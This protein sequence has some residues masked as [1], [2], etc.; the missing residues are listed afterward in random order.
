MRSWFHKKPE[1]SM[2]SPLRT[3]FPSAPPSAIV[4]VHTMVASQCLGTRRT[5]AGC[6]AICGLGAVVFGL[7]SSE[8]GLSVGLLFIG[9]GGAGVQICLQSTSALFPKNRSLVMASLS[10]SFQLASSVFLI[11]ET[12]HRLVQVSRQALFLG[13]AAILLF[14]SGLSLIIW[15]VLPF[16]VTRRLSNQSPHGLPVEQKVEVLALKDRCFRDQ[17][18]SPEYIVMVAYFTLAV[19]QAQFIIQTLGVQFQLMGLNSAGLVR[20]FNVVFSFTWTITPLVG[21]AI[22]KCGTVRVLIFMNTLLLCCPVCLLTQMYPVQLAFTFAYG[23]SRVS[24]WAAYFSYVGT[25]FG[26]SNYGKLAGGGLFF[27]AFVSLLQIPLLHLTLIFFGGDF[28]FVNCLFAAICVSMYPLIGA[29][30]VMERKAPHAATCLAVRKPPAPEPSSSGD[31]GTDAP[32][33]VQAMPDAG[34][35]ARGGVESA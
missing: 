8:T 24:I 2:T 32:G 29:L 7:A 14:V 25:I 20:I 17:V 13:Y 26:F 3:R 19:L 35:P 34:A 27:A 1:A 4:L 31:D 11:M 10:G 12:M 5:T 22:D 30:E 21:H 33:A 28:T 23:I 6:A 15:P 9:V 18:F 16:G